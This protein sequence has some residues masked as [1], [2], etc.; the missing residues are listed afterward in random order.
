[1]TMMG[2]GVARGFMISRFLD[3][4]GWLKS[5]DTARFKQIVCL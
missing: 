1:M 2:A 4:S 5:I 3:L